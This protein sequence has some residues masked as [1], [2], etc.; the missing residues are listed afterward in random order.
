MVRIGFAV[1]VLICYFELIPRVLLLFMSRQIQTFQVLM[2]E[3]SKSSIT[4]TNLR[5]T[6][7]RRLVLPS[8]R[9][10]DQ[11]K[12]F[13]QVKVDILVITESELD[14]YSPLNQF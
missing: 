9:K 5:N 4:I 12:P 1:R 14:K 11:L 2:N 13:V 6:K 3:R 8:I 7:V 10:F